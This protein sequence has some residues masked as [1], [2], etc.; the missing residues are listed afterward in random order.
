MDH[1]PGFEATPQPSEIDRLLDAVDESRGFDLRGY[2]R[3]SLRRRIASQMEAEGLS[4]PAEY[5]ERIKADERCFRRLVRALSLHSTPMFRQPGFYAELRETV[6]PILRTYPS[7]NIWL[8]ECSA[9]EQAYGTA[10]ALREEG[11]LD[12][13]RIYATCVSEDVLEVAKRGV[14]AAD[15]L[16]AAARNYALAGG[17]SS[18]S[19]YVTREGAEVSVRPLLRERIVF[20]QHNVATD[21]SFNE[22]HLI[23][24]RDVMI[25]FDVAT[26]E[27]VFRLL[28]A[29]LCR[30]GVVGL[31]TGESLRLSPHLDSYEPIGHGA[32]LY[33]RIK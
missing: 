10:I 16:E 17:K 7:V 20:A 1:M 23:V 21:A 26:Q 5:A 3:A 9:G 29:S 27:R 14:Y 4:R 13:S 15:S 32:R 19:E 6:V 31:G 33:R 2:A 22:F 8:P 28:H 25:Y 18:L 24:C 12:K 11:V 30:F